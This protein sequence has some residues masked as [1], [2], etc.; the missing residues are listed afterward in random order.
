MSSNTYAGNYEIVLKDLL[1]C[2]MWASNPIKYVSKTHSMTREQNHNILLHL[3]NVDKVIEIIKPRNPALDTPVDDNTDEKVMISAEKLSISVEEWHRTHDL[4]ELLDGEPKYPND[5]Y[6][7]FINIKP[8]FEEFAEKILQNRSVS[9]DER[10]IIESGKISYKASSGMLSINNIELYF[11]SK[12]LQ[13][14]ILMHTTR[15]NK[16]A[17]GKNII[18]SDYLKFD[19]AKNTVTEDNFKKAVNSINQKV[20]RNIHI[21]T[22]LLKNKGEK[23]LINPSFLTQIDK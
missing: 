23:I 4:T 9:F 8:K 18:E 10:K 19:T 13:G 16:V 15:R 1:T 11:D 6:Y 22:H 3:Q 20:M 5:D 14:R 12:T 7:Y 21:N 17:V 2:S